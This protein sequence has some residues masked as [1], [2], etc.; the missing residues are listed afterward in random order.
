M[1]NYI[2]SMSLY[3]NQK[4]SFICFVLESKGQMFSF[5]LDSLISK[6]LIKKVIEGR[7]I[8]HSKSVSEYY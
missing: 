8:K 5:I 7:K 1:I 6:Q 3:W 4:K 2:L